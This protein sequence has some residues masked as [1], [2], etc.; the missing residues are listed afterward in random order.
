MATITVA[1]YTYDTSGRL[2]R[3]VD[4][5]TNLGLTTLW[6][7][8]STRLA[9]VKATGL[10]AQRLTYDTTAGAPRVTIAS[11]DDAAGGATA[12]TTTR[13]QYGIA[14][15]GSSSLPDLSASAVAAWNQASAPATGYAVFGLDDPGNCCIRGQLYYADAQGYIVNTAQYGAGA[16]QAPQ[17]TTTKRATPS[18]SLTRRHQH[19]EGGRRQRCRA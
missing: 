18:A 2:I 5:R 1:S 16:W 12:V 11:R 9:S 4:P 15:T 8:T 14:V 19:R 17:R 6:D 7:G 13:I 3:V 10:A